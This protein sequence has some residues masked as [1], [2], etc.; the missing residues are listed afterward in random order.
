MISFT[1][2][3][4]F[5]GEQAPKMKLALVLTSLLLIQL[6]A[7]RTLPSGVCFHYLIYYLIV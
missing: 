5:E 3:K 6:V 2:D 4:S 1:L 7:A